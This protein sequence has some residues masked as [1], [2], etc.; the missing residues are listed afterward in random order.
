MCNRPSA[1]ASRADLDSAT[2]SAVAFEPAPAIT[3]TRF[4][5][6][7]TV[8]RTTS[9]CSSWL[10]VADSPVVPH[11]T[12]PS[13]PPAICA[14]TSSSRPFLSIAPPR[15]GVT[16]AVMAPTNMPGR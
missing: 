15:I 3:G 6:N 14:S 2:A 7:C 16:R 11:G 10:S 4:L 8:R 1:P 13:I 12:S 5:A 9:A